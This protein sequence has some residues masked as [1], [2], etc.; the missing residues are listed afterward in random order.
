[1]T[2]SRVAALVALW[3]VLVVAASTLA[4]TVISRAGEEVS[5][6]PP[7][8]V[9]ATSPTTGSRTGGPQDD[10]PTA[11][12]GSI[13][14]TWQGAAGVVVVACSGRSARLVSAQP[15]VGFQAELKDGGPDAVEVEFEGTGS[16]DDDRARIEAR[17]VDGA[18]E[19]SA[20]LD[21]DG[22]PSG[23][24]QTGSDD[25]GTQTGSDDSGGTQ[26][27]SDGSGTQTSSDDG[28][29]DDHGGDDHGGDD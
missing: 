22:S 12:G 16:R 26:T 17:C 15:T 9:A 2:R 13:R 21:A 19:F 18:P 8:A 6:P 28:G 10:G 3:L 29:G 1:M 11:T 20:D 27:G 14:G 4:W 7:P 23:T 5:S 24:T 25:S